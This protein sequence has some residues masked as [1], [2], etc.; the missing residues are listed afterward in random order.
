MKKLILLSFSFF[1][2]NSTYSQAYM[3][4]ILEKT[5]NCIVEL[6]D[7]LSTDQFNLE[8]GAC[9]IEASMPFKKQL[10]KDYDIDL[11]N[12]ETDAGK[13]G[14]LIGLKMASFCPDMLMKLTGRSKVDNTAYNASEY[15]M[16]TIVK[17]ENDP[18]VVFSLKDETGK[19]TKLYWLTFIESDIELTDNYLSLQG[20]FVK[21]SYT[22]DEFFDPKIV[23]YR[24][25]QIIKSI[26]LI[27]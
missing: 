8:I 21:I 9:M 25:F 11:D 2:I 24:Q 16:G 23:Q 22:T 20:K 17:I 19:I 3:D 12:I 14:K 15:I 5:C 10:K 6:P 26:K 13:L 27:K 7:T 4:K 1:L 18:F